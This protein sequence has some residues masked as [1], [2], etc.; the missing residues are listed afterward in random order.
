VP[1]GTRRYS[2]YS[3]ES[4]LVAE[5]ALS[6]AGAPAIAHEYIWFDGHPVAQVDAGGATHWTFTDH[7][8]TPLL[9]TNSDGSTYW[10]AEYEPFGAVFALRSDD[11]HQPLRLPGQEAE[12]LDLGANGVTE[13]E[14]N[15][16]RWYRGA[17]GRY[18]Q[19]DPIGFRGG[20]NWYAYANENPVAFADPL[21]L[22]V[23]IC[24]KIIPPTLDA[25]A[26]VYALSGY[27]W[28]PEGRRHC[29]FEFDMGAF[30]TIGLHW[31]GEEHAGLGDVVD[32]MNCHALAIIHPD[33]GFDL[34][35]SNP[36]TCGPWS[37]CEA[38]V[39][40]HIQEYKNPSIYCL[41][42]PNSN[43][44]VGSGSRKCGVKAPAG[45]TEGTLA[46]G[47]HDAQP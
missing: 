4:S 38:C 12:Q 14:Y 36:K 22:R 6:A 18:T 5:T 26:A 25:A 41:F 2:F 29:F 42:G 46:P 20:N 3:R 27:T 37:V 7:L 28:L 44:F 33:H 10:R 34:P 11:V 17:W 35:D 8:G 23:R 16:N 19:R 21:G 45:E 9:L 1:A 47:Y 30:Q 24:C 43:T 13:R 15:V 31:V 39:Y 32:A 40:K